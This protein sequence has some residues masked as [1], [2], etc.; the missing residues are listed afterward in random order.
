MNDYRQPE[1]YRFN[2]D[3]LKLVKKVCDEV[4]KANSIL[5]MGA[6]SGIIGI[7]LARLLKANRL[8]LLEA[9]TDYHSYLEQ[10]IKEQL[11]AE[12]DSEVMLSS[13]GKWEPQRVYDLIVCNPPYF[14][15]GSGEPSKDTRRNIARSFIID[16]WEILL[17]KM[18]KALSPEGRVYIVVRDDKSVIAEIEKYTGLNLK[19]SKEGKLVFIK[20]SR[21]NIN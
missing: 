15:S 7:E 9:Q 2:E 11:P 19:L 5:D 21:L 4:Q 14:L 17:T 10:N 16:N 1:F 3:S 13:F 12:I 20:L 6:G 8:D 18:E